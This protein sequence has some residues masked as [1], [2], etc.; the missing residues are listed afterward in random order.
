[1]SLSATR[2]GRK[3]WSEVQG[4]GQDKSVSDSRPSQSC[5]L[6]V[7]GFAQKRPSMH[8]TMARL[9]AGTRLSSA[10]VG[11]AVREWR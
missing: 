11:D 3:K 8:M 10:A 9:Y 1:M 5:G 7:E 4:M 6:V 2:E